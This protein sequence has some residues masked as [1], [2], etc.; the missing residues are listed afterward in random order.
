M[1]E[2][3][4]C[5]KRSSVCGLFLLT[6]VLYIG[7]LSPTIAWRD[8]PEFVTVAHVLGISHPAGSP[9]YALVAKCMTFLPIGSIAL[10]VNLCSALFGALTVSLLF[11]FLYE[12]LAG[13]ALWTRLCAAWSG[14]LFLCVSA[15]F[16]R[17]AEVA[18]VYALQDC[19]IIILLTVLLKARI[20]QIVTPSV[21]RKWYW[22]FAFLYGLST[23]VHATMAFFA[24]AFL[25]FIGLIEPHMFRGKALA[26]AMFFFVMGLTVYL[27]LPFRS[28]AEPVFN[29]GDPHTFRQLL[30]HLSD[31]KDGALHFAF[32]W[33]KLP[34]QI[35]IYLVNLCN[36]FSTL[37]VALG[38]LGCLTISYKEKSFG[39]LLGLVFLGN[40]GFFIRTWTAAFG[41]LPSFVIYSI[42]IGFGVHTCLA[43]LATAYQQWLIHIPRV[44]V[45]TFLFGSIAAT[46]G[47][48][49]MR[50][51]AVTDQTGN[52]SAALY[53]QHLLRQLPSDAILFSDY[54]WFPLLY[55]Q[56]V[57]RQRPDLTVLLQGDVLTPQYYAPLSHKRF[58]NIRLASSPQPVMMSTED[59]LL[60]L[61]KINHE[62]HSLFWDP[63]P[64]HAVSLDAHFLPQGLLFAFNPLQETAI[65]PQVLRTHR[66]LVA[67][68][69]TQI[70]TGSDDQD[71]TQMLASKLT[72]I[73]R[74]LKK[75]GFAAE[76]AQ[77]YQTG[78]SIRPED[79][80]LRNEYGRW[81]MSRGQFQQALAQFNAGYNSNPIFPPLNKNLGTLLL[82]AG[83]NI[84]AAHFFE[85]ALAFGR[86][87][88]D[89]YALLGETYIR[90]GRWPAAKQALATALKLY[91]E[92]S[93][94][95]DD[96]DRRQ[97]KI[98]WA[99]ETLHRL[100]QGLTG[101]LTPLIPA[102]HTVQ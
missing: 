76:A 24:P 28:L 42:W 3:L 90:L 39:L 62:D 68:A 89:L 98:A 34:Y 21:A 49:Y 79:Y 50:H 16:W 92:T 17:F 73:G 2:H 25:V 91:A 19:L 9:T 95:D 15:S 59:Y 69:T 86:G 94:T 33:S 67:H 83:D 74:Y 4:W 55:L 13:T 51:L 75:R 81:L 48:T 97:G 80:Y 45:Y 38:L 71:A 99:R 61:S 12:M 7:T 6:S 57:E 44:A 32:S 78:L 64:D 60:F 26:F 100:A 66:Q 14:A 93:A 101:S 11:F 82:S 84:Q 63:E 29:W 53:G 36:E 58:P 30:I 43:L 40:V 47:G 52:Y 37:G 27:Y 5:G 85:R 65:T 77:M 54:S 10:R 56:N 70:L 18:E 102:G 46:L 96:A 88:G 20:A 23:G 41:F 1:Y 87:D 22:L 72:F 8:S 31:R 35:H